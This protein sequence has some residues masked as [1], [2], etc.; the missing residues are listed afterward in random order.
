MINKINEL[1]DRCQKRLMDI[2]VELSLLREPAGE[3]RMYL[4][5]QEAEIVHT[6]GL[7]RE[8]TRYECRGVGHDAPPQYVIAPVDANMIT[9]GK[10]YK[11]IRWLNEYE[12]F[13]I[14]HDRGVEAN[15]RLVGCAWIGGG[16]WEVQDAS[17]KK[18]TR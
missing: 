16:D 1:L 9:K 17:N 15:C 3:K 5:G 2:Q 7:L 14:L 12:N 11:I 10:R 13:I 18:E 6:I 8:L 4:L